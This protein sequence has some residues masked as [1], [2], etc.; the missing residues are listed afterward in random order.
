MI[1]PSIDVVIATHQR[2]DLLRRAIEGVTSQTYPGVIRCLVVFDRSSPDLSLVRTG[3]HRPVDVLTNTRTPGLAGARNCGIL[4]G[5]G[6]LVAFCDDDDAWLPEK[7]SLQVRKLAEHAGPTS[8]TG[9]IIEYDGHSI[10]RIPDPEDLTLA[11]LARNRVMAAHPSSVMVRRDALVNDIG[12]VDEEIPGSYG[13]DFDWI[14]RAAE[15]GGFAVVTQPLV[16]V[17]WGGSQFSRQWQTI[18][19]AIDYGLAKHP[20]F[21]EDPRALGRLYGRRAFAL[22]ALGNREALP[23]VARTLRV[24]PT[25]RRAWLA[26]AVALHLVSAER[27]MDLAHRRGHGI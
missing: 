1:P 26:A 20:V 24:A 16:R 22:A 9:I 8:V 3:P 18:I 6:D 23:A 27:L 4:A 2:P 25:E 12:L 10:V 13:E 5:E 17:K 15:V 11:T 14:L 21:H 7:A 19:D